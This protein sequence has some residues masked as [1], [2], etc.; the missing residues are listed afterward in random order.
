MAKIKV[1]YYLFSKKINELKN[2]NVKSYAL[3]NYN[4]LVLNKEI[5]YALKHK[6]Y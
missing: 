6:T 1:F 3:F 2:G 5:M 4:D